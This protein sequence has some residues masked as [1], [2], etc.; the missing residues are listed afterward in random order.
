[1]LKDYSKHA[2]ALTERVCQRARQI[3][4]GAGRPYFYVPVSDRSKPAGN[5]RN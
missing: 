4:E 5:N 3:A 2:Q 1:L